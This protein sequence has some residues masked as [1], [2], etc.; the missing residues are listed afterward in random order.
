[1]ISDLTPGTVQ[2]HP[3][4]RFPFYVPQA[5]ICHS[6]DAFILEELRHGFGNILV[7]AVEQ[8]IIALHDGDTAAQT[9]HRLGKFQPDIAATENQQMFRDD[10]EL[11]RFDMSERRGL[12]ETGYV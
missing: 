10:V 4:A 7:L 5:G 2:P 9:T 12:G 3:L 6:D 1:M 8:A 11:Q